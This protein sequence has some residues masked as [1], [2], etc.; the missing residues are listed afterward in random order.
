MFF[1]IKDKNEYFCVAN[2][3]YKRFLTKI[4]RAYVF[5]EVMIT[6]V[7]YRYANKRFRLVVSE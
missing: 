6:A 3:L 4:S 1:R 7:S 2:I 5:E